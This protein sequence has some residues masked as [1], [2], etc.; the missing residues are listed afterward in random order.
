MKPIHLKIPSNASI[1]IAE[2]QLLLENFTGRTLQIEIKSLK[3][4]KWLA[5]VLKDGVS[6]L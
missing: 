3:D 1:P 4:E 2:I 6:S 5:V